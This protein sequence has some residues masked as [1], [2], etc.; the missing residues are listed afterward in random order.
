MC[1]Q[2]INTVGRRELLVSSGLASLA[3]VAPAGAKSSRGDVIVLGDFEAGV[4]GWKTDGGNKF[5][6]VTRS[7]VG[8]AVSSGDYAL[9]VDGSSDPAPLIERNVADADFVDHPYLL[10]HVYVPLLEGVDSSV[11]FELRFR[12]DRSGGANRSNGGGDG[13]GRGEP[14]ETLDRIEV[15]QQFDSLLFWDFSTLSEEK[16]ANPN[17]LELFWYRTDAPPKNG[18]HGRGPG[19][20]FGETVYFDDIH[21]TDSRR[22]LEGSA[23]THHLAMLQ[24]RHGIPQ[25][26]DESFEDGVEHGRMEFTDGSKIP[27]RTEL[28]DD[29]RILYTVGDETFELGGEK[30]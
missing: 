30:A 7:D 13:K 21:L 27:V 19:D 26:V 2:Q 6:R 18:P 15:P 28:L 11:T 8:P 22:A 9:A 4:D 29:G 5:D 17:R 3:L 14:V 10:A 1:K 24:G 23:L 20:G 12:H 16:R 25:Y